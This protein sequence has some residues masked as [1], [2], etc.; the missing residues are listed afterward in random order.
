MVG[1]AVLPGN[2]TGYGLAT[3][4]LAIAGLVALPASSAHASSDP[5]IYAADLR[6]GVVDVIDAA[7]YTGVAIIPVG[8]EPTDVILNRSGTRAYVVNS[9]SNT[10]SVID[11]SSSTVTATISLGNYQPFGIAINQDGSMAYVAASLSN[12]AGAVMAIN[13]S[14]NTVTETIPAGSSDAGIALNSTGTVAYVG[15]EGDSALAAVDLSTD[16]VTIIPIAGAGSPSSVEASPDGTKVY[17]LNE[18]RAGATISVIDTGTNKV[19]A[20][21]PGLGDMGFN[22]AVDPTAPLI[23]APDEFFTVY[24]ANTS[25][26]TVTGTIPAI[27]NASDGVAFGADGAVA[28]VGNGASISVINTTAGTV[29]A[30]IPIGSNPFISSIAVTQTVEPTT[31]SLT[32]SP[33]QSAILGDTVTLA[34]NESPATAGTVQFFDGASPLGSPV[35][36]SSGRAAYTTTSLAL[37]SHSFT[38]VFTPSSTTFTGSTSQ[39][40]TL[41]INVPPFAI[42]QT[43][44]QNGTGTV[45]TAPFTTTG[46]RLLVAFTSSDGPATKQTTTVTGNGLTWTLIERANTK[47]G[48]AEIWAAQAT[49]PLTGA[50]VTSKPKTAGYDQSVT[51][52]AFTG[53]SGIGAGASAGKSGGLPSVS[54]AT[55]QPGTWVFGVGEDYSNAIPRTHGA[56]QSLISQWIDPRPGETFWVQDEIAPTPVAGTAVTINDTAPRGDIWNLAAVEILPA[57]S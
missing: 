9:G 57:A 55:A 46:P 29:T 27:S 34:A 10:I 18:D 26:D 36:V 35:A 32:V 31:T 42:D 56:N 22:F 16:A 50:T 41:Q 4:A 40:V 38:A 20:T 17:V 19:T 11:T 8:S 15:D 2:K 52:V 43:I 49:G 23:Y 21:I 14:T 5:L 39:P 12:G 37:G 1:V 47:G 48:T 45:T 13:T 6:G 53:A 24:V 3:A 30:A 54:L 51:V 33:S 28:Y 25:N 44:T 7:T